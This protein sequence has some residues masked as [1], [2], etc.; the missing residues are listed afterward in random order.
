MNLVNGHDI[1]ALRWVARACSTIAGREA[2]CCI[3]IRGQ[4]AYAADGKRVHRAMLETP[5]ADGLYGWLGGRVLELAQLGIDRY[6]QVDNIIPPVADNGINLVLEYNCP[7]S[8]GRV[9]HALF[10]LAAF[11]VDVVADAFRSSP[12]NVLISFCNDCTPV[13]VDIN[14][15][16]TA[17]FMPQR[18]A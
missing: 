9:Y 4:R 1:A 6:P 10:K 7:S 14:G 13:R 18:R 15:K 3:C 17:V 16:L 11:D 5:V 2:L 8:L 12:G